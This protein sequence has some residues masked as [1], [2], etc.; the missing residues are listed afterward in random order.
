M[1]H[2]FHLLLDQVTNLKGVPP[3]YFLT[4][5]ALNG[6]AHDAIFPD[7]IMRKQALL[8]NR[9]SFGA[10]PLRKSTP[11]E[12]AADSVSE[13][14]SING[15]VYISRAKAA[16]HFNIPHQLFYNRL[17][18]GWTPEQA[19]GL[20]PRRGG[21]KGA[22]NLETGAESFGGLQEVDKSAIVSPQTIRRRLKN[23]EPVEK[24]L[25]TAPHSARAREK[26]KPVPPH[27]LWKPII[28]EGVRYPSHSEV[29]RAY[30]IPPTIFRKRLMKGWSVEEALA[31]APRP[32]R[33]AG[34]AITIAG[35]T[36][37]SHKAAADHYRVRVGTFN[38]RLVALG[39]SPEEAAGL[40]DH[41]K[42]RA[43]YSKK[44]DHQGK[45]LYLSFP[46]VG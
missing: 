43:S 35:V 10:H 40:V 31:I 14:I 12:T 41:P 34:K 46:R 3:T 36:F 32:Q 44:D 11:R 29:A 9:A 26:Q 24:A 4:Y 33:R 1:G 30:G 27:P 6:F 22:L 16:E 21:G 37:K 5:R 28:V 8:R 17:W 13:E 39:W 19:V 7:W 20:T 45:T 25:R 42:R 2:L 15:V 23:G 18:L 38:N